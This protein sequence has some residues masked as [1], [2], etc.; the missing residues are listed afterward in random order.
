MLSKVKLRSWKE[1]KIKKSFIADE[2]IEIITCS[3]QG[4]QYRL[5]KRLLVGFVQVGLPII[6]ALFCTGFFVI[7]KNVSYNG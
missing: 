1:D 4:G 5:Y 2:I 3:V 7:G 6:L